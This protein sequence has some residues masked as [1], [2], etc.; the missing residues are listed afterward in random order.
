MKRAEKKRNENIA[1]QVKNGSLLVN[2]IDAYKEEHPV[3]SDM[4]YGGLFS[5][6]EQ[7]PQIMKLFKLSLLITPSTA[8]MERGFS[9]LNLVHTKQRNR[10]AVKSLD[11]LMR[12]VL[13][14]PKKLD[15]D[16]YEL[17]V[18]KYRDMSDRR[19]VL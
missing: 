2:N 11:M 10:L 6:R 8:N 19:I 14:G 12:I 17:L 7:Y 18:N 1:L 9:V 16:V 3:A 4:I 13:V 5:E 15:G